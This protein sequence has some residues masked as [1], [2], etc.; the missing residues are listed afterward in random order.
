MMKVY[1]DHISESNLLLFSS[2]PSRQI[3][4]QIPA[5]KRKASIMIASGLRRLCFIVTATVVTASAAAA[6]DASAWDEDT[7]SGMRLIAGNAPQNA[8]DGALR[9]GVELKI[10][11]GWKTYWRY[12]GD[13][14]VPPRFDFTQSTNVKDVTIQWPLPHRFADGSGYSI[15]YRDAVIFPLRVI[16]QDKSLPVTLRLK[17]EYAVCEK[18]C[19]P[20][21]AKAD[22]AL[23]RGQSSQDAAL[24]AA[25]AQVPKPVSLSEGKAFAIRSVR[26]DSVA[27]KPLVV[28]DVMAPEHFS[29]DLFAEG[30]SADWALPLP[31]AMAEAPSGERRFTFE[32]DGL[33]PGA[34]ATDPATLTLTAIAGTDAIEVK[35]HLD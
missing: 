33:P 28:V 9:A 19:V 25:E 26:R 27:G 4:F 12:P 20:V 30:P 5:R 22:L 2:S 31:K 15:G 35:A 11:A 34:K 23:S 14:G 18:L 3:Q 32:L 8:A 7:R 16:P 29:V 24:A 17:L 21:G 1:P 6:A 10:A 13:S